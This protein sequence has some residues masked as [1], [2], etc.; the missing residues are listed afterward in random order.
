VHEMLPVAMGAAAAL[1]CSRLASPRLRDS[2]FAALILA[3]G[4]L[5]S[6][7]NGEQQSWPQFIAADVFFAMTGAVC[8]RVGAGLL[9]RAWPVQLASDNIETPL[10]APGLTRVDG[11][12][13]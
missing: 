1:V 5:A 13:R 2:L 9:R 6:F 7:V 12:L 10:Q 3:T 4:A 8:A 11:Y